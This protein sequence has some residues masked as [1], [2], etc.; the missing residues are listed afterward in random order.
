MGLATAPADESTAKAP[1]FGLAT[2][3]FV[4]VSSMVG[5][6]VLTTSGYT[7]YLVGSNQLMLVLWVIGGVVAVCGAL[8]LAELSAALPRSG[9]DYVFLYE[10]YGPLAAF[11]S[12]WVSFL[13]GFG[14]PI[15]A[16]AF[17]AAKYLLAPLRLDNATAVLA[18]QGVASVAILAFAAIHASGRE[19]TIRVQ[20]GITVLKLGILGLL[21]VAGLAAGWGRWTHLADRPSPGLDLPRLV[22]IT[23]SLV[24]ISYAYTGWN[25]AGYLAGEVEQPQRR[26]PRAILLGTALVVALYLA[27]NTTYALALSVEDLRGIVNA[28][29][30][31]QGLDA[32]APIARLAADRLFGPRLADPLSVAIGLTLLAS[33]SAYVLTGPRV[34]YAMARAGQFPAI[35][36]RL[37]RRQTPAIATALQVAWALVVL[38]TGSFESIM[39]YSGFGLALFSM[40]TV[41]AVYVLRWRR[42]DLPRPFATPGYPIVPAIYLVSTGLLAAA[43][44]HERRDVS[45][46]SLLSILAGVPVYYLSGTPLMNPKALWGLLRSAAS[47]WLEDKAP[48][49]GAALAYYTIFSVAPLLLIAIA[50][51]GLVFGRKAAQGQIVGQIQHMM[52]KQGAEAIEEMIKNASKPEAGYT[53]TGIGIVL[54][55]FGAT[56]LFGQLQDAMNTI[57][58]VQLKPGRGI[59]GF[60]KDRFLSFGMVM[61]TVFLLLVSLVVS[62]GLAAMG[63]LLGDWGTSAVGQVINFV[64]SFAV[65]TGLFAMIFR[66]L[67]D[68]KVAWRDVWLGSALTALLFT[69]GKTAIGLYLGH[70]SVASAY[71]AAGSLVVLLIWAYYSAQIFLFGAEFI[72]TYANQYGSRIVPEKDA[73]PVT[74]QAR[75]EQGIPRR[76]GSEPGISHRE[77]ERER[78]RRKRKG[79][80]S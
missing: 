2:T 77:R 60:V 26:L 17:A 8:T 54:L 67:P 28:P 16:S 42:P 5:T 12:G 50:V 34:A 52:G 75:A 72:K 51:A 31:D 18:Q 25:A 3:T 9:G 29:G 1:G 38:W 41:S 55:V 15:A 27:L 73:E 14:G 49:L 65:I 69:I 19:R 45:T 63:S 35:A 62:A 11:L 20:G 39:L 33:L 37:S 68:A 13:I 32:L 10:A 78:L 79:R 21:A 58:E 44:F 61:G 40:L 24:Y 56:G 47:E 46:V 43:V 22:T 76:E 7:A 70:S 74:G 53:A 57:W 64:V 66:F 36:G 30:N 80:R 59:W 71:G 23:S 4:V 6:G 48:R